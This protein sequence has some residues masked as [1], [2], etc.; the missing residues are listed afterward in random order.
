NQEDRL[1]GQ[2]LAAMRLHITI[3]NA[4]YD[5][6]PRFSI[7]RFQSM[8]LRSKIALMLVALGLIGIEG[9]GSSSNQ[10]GAT[11]SGAF[12]N[13]SL[14]GTYIFSFSGQDSSNGFESYF[15]ILGTLTANGSGSFTG[16]TI[17]IDDPALGAALNTGYAFNRLPTSGNYSITADGRG[18]ATISVTINGAQV[19]FGLDF[20]LTSNS[21]GLISRFDANGSGSGTID[22]QAS[23]VTQSALQGSY[24]FG[25]QGADSTV[26]NSLATVGS[27]SLDGNGNV[28][29]GLQDFA[30]N[31]DS[32]GLKA[33]LVHG[34]V[35]AG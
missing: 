19:Q 28:I 13:N 14:N 15:A 10:A 1:L 16:G 25:L 8:F 30:D 35:L 32:R 23:N 17:D 24:A 29:S 12:S 4:S 20:V 9:C 11:P 7:R 21:H 2:V 6:E 22:L 33:L 31:G 3:L 34:S 18:T 26:L 27:F 5:L